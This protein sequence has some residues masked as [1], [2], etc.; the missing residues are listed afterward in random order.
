VCHLAYAFPGSHPF[1]T[2]FSM[3]IPLGARCLL[4]GCN[5]A[6]MVSDRQNGAL[7]MCRKL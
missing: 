6:G 4:L 1:M 2:D 3:D 7:C 5:G